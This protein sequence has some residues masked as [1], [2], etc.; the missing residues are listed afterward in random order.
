MARAEV[1]LGEEGGLGGAGMEWNPPNTKTALVRSG[2]N[3]VGLGEAEVAPALRRAAS[4]E[5]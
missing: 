5:R 3:Q 1:N 2:V 4:R